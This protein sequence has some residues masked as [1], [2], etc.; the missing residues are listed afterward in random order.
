M[1]VGKDTV[2]AALQLSPAG[3]LTTLPLPVPLNTSCKPKDE[4]AKVA[5]TL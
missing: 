3:L 1:L 2:H 4:G 5:V